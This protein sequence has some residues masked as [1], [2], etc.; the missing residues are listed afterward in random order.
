MK[1]GSGKYFLMQ[2]DNLV[3]KYINFI[4]DKKNIVN[5]GD[6]VFYLQ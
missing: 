4:L 3:G 1:G 6:R 5:I 2:A